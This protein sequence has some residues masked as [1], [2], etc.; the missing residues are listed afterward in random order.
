MARA[1]PSGGAAS[2]S[3]A[4]PMRSFLRPHF[5]ARA[6][7]GAAARRRA[8]G[9]WSWPP[10]WRATPSTAT[11]ARL[12]ACLGT[13][14]A[15]ARWV[16]HRPRRA[17]RG[18][19]AARR[20]PDAGRA[21]LHRG[22]QRR[23]RRLRLR[24]PHGRGVR[25]AARVPRLRRGARRCATSPRTGAWWTRCSP[26]GRARGGGGA[27]ARGHRGLGRRE[28]PRRPGDPARGLRGARLRVRAR[29][30]ARAGAPRRAARAPAAARSTSSIA[31][32][33]SP[34]WWSARTR[35]A[36]SWT[37]IASGAA[38]FVNSL[39][40]PGSRRTRRSSPC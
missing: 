5:V 16:A 26:R 24:R 4:Q 28:D 37:P 12:C 29:R 2:P 25:A 34:S 3:T 19:L 27:P 22:Q 21:A 40:L 6:A 36:A 31:A 17:R 15:E 32:A 30:P 38:V 8:R 9:C 23:A 11:S 1:K 13:P 18:A 14:E 7:L 35:C 33:C 39:P 20:V 10:A